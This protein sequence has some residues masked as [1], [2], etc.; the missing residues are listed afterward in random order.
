MSKEKK[1]FLR[2]LFKS[3]GGCNCGVQVV[4]EK[5]EKKSNDNKDKESSK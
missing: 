3:S 5:N 4:E 2:K 1:S